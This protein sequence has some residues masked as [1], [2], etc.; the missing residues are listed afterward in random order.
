MFFDCVIQ[1][2]NCATETV[3][4]DP[5]A[6]REVP[7]ADAHPHRASLRHR[8]HAGAIGQ[9]TSTARLLLRRRSAVHRRGQHGRALAGQAHRIQLRQATGLTP[10]GVAAHSAA[11]R[12]RDRGIA[13]ARRHPVRA[14]EGG[15]RAALAGKPVPA[16][17][18]QPAGAARGHPHPGD[19][20][21]DLGAPRQRRGSSGPPAVG[22]AHRAH[23]QHGA[24]GAVG[25][26][27]ADV[28]DALLHLEPICAGM[29]AC[30]RGSDDR[31]GAVPRGRNRSADRTVR[32]PV[33]VCAE[34]A[35][36]SRGR[37]S[38]GV[39]TSR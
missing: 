38:P 19:R 36:V 31:G 13:A 1:H 6:E 27:P 14:P 23:D 3:G 30:A 34:R 22:G 28:S 5:V 10:C 37:S 20:R 11:A 18:C 7:Q 26:T 15:R 4:Q 17:R 9:V 29:C 25:A 35:A 39:A 2:Q 32:R 12:R 33:A 24:A 21:P 16:V 8:P